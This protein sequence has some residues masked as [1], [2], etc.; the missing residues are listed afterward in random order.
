MDWIRCLLVSIIC[1][2]SCASLAEE[3]SAVSPTV[4]TLPT[5][6]GTIQGLG[7]G[8]TTELNTG[9]SQDK[10]VLLFPKGRNNH[11]PSLSLD[12]DSGFGNGILGVGRRLNLPYIKRQTTN[13]LP[14]YK[15]S[16]PDVYVNEQG[17]E[18]VN[19]GNGEFR[20][21]VEGQF[22]KYQ[23]LA[24]GWQVHLPN[25]AVWKLG[26][27]LESTVTN[28]DGSQVYQWYID[29][30]KDSN[31][32]EIAY[33]YSALDNTQSVYLTAMNYNDNKSGA[34]FNYE[35]RPDPIINFRPSFEFTQ[36]YRLKSVA[37]FNKNSPVYTYQF[38][39]EP[40][41]DWQMLSRLSKIE[42]V[43]ANGI[44]ASPATT[45]QYTEFSKSAFTTSYIPSGQYL[46]VT[47]KDA[48]FIDINADG[49]PDFINTGFSPNHYWINQGKN[50][51][52]EVVFSS[53]KKMSTHSRSKLSSP[54]VKWADMTGDGKVN[55]LN[56]TSRQTN[57]F[58]LDSNNDWQPDGDFG[59]PQLQLQN[60]N[61]RLIDI[62]HDRLADIFMTVTNSRGSVIAHSVALNNGTGWD[63][64]ITMPIPRLGLGVVLGRSNTFMTDMNG[65]GLADLVYL[66]KSR[67]MFFPNRGINGFGEA[68]DFNSFRNIGRELY[69][70]ENVRFADLNHDG[71]SDLIYLNGIRVVVWPN[72]GQSAEQGQFAFGDPMRLEHPDRIAPSK[73]SVADIDGNGVTDIVWF[74]AG[75]RD[76]S[77]AYIT[78]VPGTL[79]NQLKA[80]NN[81]IG[82][83]SEI[84]YGTLAVEM[85]RDRDQGKAWQQM[86]P[87]AM[88]IVK[89]VT[90]RDASRA[91]L[92]EIKR[93]HYH[94]GYYS[95]KERKFVGF[96]E[97]EQ[98]DAASAAAKG[99]STH[100]SFLL[101]MDDES[102]RGK[103]Y[104]VVKKDLNNAIYWQETAQWQ[105][106]KLFDSVDDP[107]RKVTFAYVS[108]RKRELIEQGKGTPVT[109]AWQYAYDD[110]GN[111]IR[112]LEKG[113]L[114]NQW[115]DERET[116]WRFSAEEQSSLDHWQLNKPIEK[117][118]KGSNGNIVTKEQW[119]YDDE[120]HT[121]GQLGVVSK[122]NLTAHQRWVNPTM[123]SETVFAKRY[124][125]DASGNVT[126]I[127]GPLYGK[128]SGHW[129]TI[130]YQDGLNP[131]AENIHLGGATL[132]AKASYDNPLGL[133]SSFSDFNASETTFTY[134]GLGRVK[135][136][137]RPGDSASAPTQTFE[138]HYQQSF[139]GAAVNWVG[140][141]QRLEAGGATIV[142][143]QYYDGSGRH[144]MT[145][146]DSEQGV[147][148]RL[149]LQYDAR[150]FKSK[151]RL[152]YF[153][154]SLA[155]Q[156]NT[157]SP[158]IKSEYDGLGRL[159]R[160]HNP[161]TASHGATYS[162]VKYSPQ[163]IWFQD[164]AQTLAGGVHA[165]AGKWLVYDG[166]SQL[167]EVRENVG[168]DRDGNISAQ[169]DW[170]TRY[171][172]DVVGNFTR[173][174]DAF[175]NIR[176][177][178][179]DGLGRNTYINDPNRG[180][181]WHQYD[182]ASN[183]VASLNSK[184]IA[185]FY[186]YDGI[187]RLTRESTY[188]DKTAVPN[189]GGVYPIL[190]PSK[191]KTV[192][193]YRYDSSQD[194]T[195]HHL[196]GRLAEVYDEAGKSWFGYDANG[197][198]ALDKRQ[199]I[200]LG[201]RTAVFATQRTY[202]SAGKV[203]RLTYPDKTYADYQYGAG[204]E[205]IAIPGVVDSLAFNAT[206]R[207]SKVGL[208]NGVTSDYSYD[209]LDRLSHLQ[210]T[211]S[212]DRTS[213]QSL[214]YEYDAASNLLNISDGRSLD[215][216]RIIAAELGQI[217]NA[218]DLDQSRSYTYDDWYRLATEQNKLMLTEYK[219]DPIG[220]LMAKNVSHP[221][222]ADSSLTLRYGGS[223]DNSN[224]LRFNR[225]GR[226]AGERSGPNALTFGKVAIDYDEIGNRTREGNQYYVWDHNNR[227][228]S[229]KNDT[230]QA[231]YAYDYNNKRRI[232]WVKDNKGKE[233][234]VFYISKDA[235]IRAGKMIKFVRLGK[236]RIAKT[237]KA[238]GP[239][240]PS[241]FYLKQHLGSTE[242][243]VNAEAKVINA[244]NYEPFGE[245]EAK[246]GLD[247]ETNYRF[248]DKEQDKE[249]GLG[250][251][252]Q[253]YLDH[254]MG[255]FITPD[256]VFATSARFTDPQQWSP[257]TY[258]RGNP[259]KYS[260]PD[261]EDIY[262]DW[263]WV[264]NAAKM[265]KASEAFAK[266]EVESMHQSMTNFQNAASEV[267]TISATVAEQAGYVSATC[268]VTGAVTGNKTLLS[269][270]KVMGVVSASASGVNVIADAVDGGEFDVINAGT[271]VISV[272]TGYMIDQ[273]AVKALGNK[274]YGSSKDAVDAISKVAG[275]T[276]NQ[277][278]RNDSEN[279]QKNSNSNRNGGPNSHT[280]RVNSSGDESKNGDVNEST[281]DNSPI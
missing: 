128:K 200:A 231:D 81:G 253:R 220:N 160:K 249:S 58:S 144:L 206:G 273:A 61:A 226:A 154:S 174:I 245:L 6:P 141:H 19:I 162:E 12:Y 182:A 134:D 123:S 192:V 188:Q 116:L 278:G 156:M 53:Q 75:K 259:L 241:L 197:R 177:M 29:S 142:S 210:T 219:F 255:Q 167:R 109:L 176:T 16:S 264:A 119:F 52:G 263:G 223:D 114:D 131:I 266:A 43:A 115:Q 178:E 86:V 172:F 55:I 22:V 230:H 69:N 5:G 89:Q 110:F 85:Q 161:A 159:I 211:R 97:A 113:R 163:K 209:A 138:Y 251:F 23:Q 214:G 184:G 191:A 165:G 155:Y 236:H 277:V 186:A 234:H 215:D 248:T 57:I 222:S 193:S 237:N 269:A 90:H 96:E 104:K 268:T 130:T 66:S 168:V 198:R 258:G 106:K 9:T 279:N 218:Y 108:E 224:S 187:N 7:E 94:N 127:Y 153:A 257:Y 271:Y 129:A 190:S 256:P 221:L 158:A 91:S 103:V 92:A 132:I 170:V 150:G 135:T 280:G 212:G 171:D 143:R 8:F 227:L 281:S 2:L 49:L 60:N 62:N 13:G 133:M 72:K 27:V 71:M 76:Q 254:S 238:G 124:K 136:I 239:F 45:Y 157:S 261:G 213:L 151:N 63:K 111:M 117:V 147:V 180:Q 77:M 79:P 225:L 120:S 252:S 149:H 10:L 152:P 80:V 146:A 125:Y 217:D 46:P 275:E 34:T 229:V 139:D 246:F 70:F 148:V 4:I 185:H 179:Y 68:I 31:G 203:T 95:A 121:A 32:N 272:G 82:H 233:S 84:S 235:E 17:N 99:A 240:N 37:A 83:E 250:Y 100:Y 199:I 56:V 93:Y 15:D 267:K 33:S 140:T 276:I 102:L 28:D 181:A 262:S 14:Q 64:P 232:K 216:K 1:T 205:L 274:M 122:G 35:K 196:K 38:G 194:N 164:S 74:R 101:G 21:K 67:L 26:T 107:S 242:L 18:L 50:A 243:S 169:Q 30:A 54:Y 207:L 204:G 24:Q 36:H 3:I 78:L 183:K 112:L 244:F 228:A 265:D 201:E 11:T 59:R 44:D 270:G 42:K 189:S 118:V 47:G 166:L 48:D 65:D 20:A 25:G 105:S 208:S 247:A 51:Q 87:L 137:V 175:G 98:V 145:V 260:D 39:Y 40:V 88:Q 195:L 73:V 41:S 202:N 173:L 126:S